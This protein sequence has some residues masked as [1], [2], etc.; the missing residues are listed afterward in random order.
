MAEEIRHLES[1]VHS[2]QRYAAAFDIL[3]SKSFCEALGKINYNARSVVSSKKYKVYYYDENTLWD[4]YR[5]LFLCQF[6]EFKLAEIFT[7]R[8]VIVKKEF[9]LKLKAN[10]KANPDRVASENND[11]ILSPASLLF[12]FGYNLGGLIEIL[13][14]NTDNFVTKQKLLE[15]LTEFNKFRVSF[16]HHSFTTDKKL[17]RVSLGSVI[18]GGIKSGIKALKMLNF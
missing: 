16:T 12:D 8:K 13:R 3:E 11:R 10:K 5:F 9:I 15:K 17:G 6:L 7:S 14:N 1:F 2:H 4:E 18:A